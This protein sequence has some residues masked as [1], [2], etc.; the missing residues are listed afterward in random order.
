MNTD[1]ATFEPP[2]D[3]IFDE[4]IEKAIVGSIPVFGIVVEALRLQP[5]DPDWHPEL[6]GDGPKVVQAIISAWQAG[7]PVQPWAYPTRPSFHAPARSV[8]KPC[9]RG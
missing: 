1:F 5:F 3:P 7:R 9:G 2:N 4:L 8:A 6:I